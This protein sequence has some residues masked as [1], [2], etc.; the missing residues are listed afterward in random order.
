MVGQGSRVTLEQAMRIIS[1]IQKISE[2]GWR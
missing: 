2:H 1:K